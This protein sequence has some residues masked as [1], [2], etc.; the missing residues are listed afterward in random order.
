MNCALCGIDAQ[1]Q[2]SHI[3]PEFAFKT[4]YDDKHRCR[5]L[6]TYSRRP[7]PFEQKGVREPLLCAECETRLSRYEHYASQ[8]IDGGV[9]S[10]VRDLRASH[11]CIDVFDLDYTKFKLFGLS[12]LWRAGVAKHSMFS[13]VRLGRHEPILRDMIMQ[14]DPDHIINMGSSS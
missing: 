11:N 8:V 6:S 7:R 1:L 10:R 4:A 5:V 9:P 14:G 12:V 13:R 2:D 3:I